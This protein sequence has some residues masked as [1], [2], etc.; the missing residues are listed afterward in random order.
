MRDLSKHPAVVIGALVVSLLAFGVSA[1]SFVQSCGVTS[2][3]REVDLHVAASTNRLALTESAGLI[4]TVSFANES[5]RAIIVR[6]VTL[7]LG[8]QRLATA[9]GYSAPE[10]G[11][12]RSQFP[13]TLEAREGRNVHVFIGDGF[14]S[15]V[16]RCLDRS[17]REFVS[18][19]ERPRCRLWRAALSR[20][21]SKQRLELRLRLT[22]GEVE[23][24]P[25]R[26]AFPRNPGDTGWGAS[27]LGGRERVMT[28]SHDGTG[29]TAGIVRLDLWRAG[30]YEFHR[31]FERPLT[32]LR[33]VFP[34]P[35]LERGAY[36]YAFR[37]NGRA[38]WSGCFRIPVGDCR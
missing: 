31:S 21:K 29:P 13:L 30:D 34:L 15:L 22:P 20:E 2:E 32:R 11:A 5:L 35:P 18:D 6:E 9:T 14:A 23:R 27:I 10:L 7:W 17:W 12:E 37:V 26:L 19:S 25:V 38:V 28:L 1:A 24:Y 8:D 33:T 36:Q 3:Q 4:V 16:Q